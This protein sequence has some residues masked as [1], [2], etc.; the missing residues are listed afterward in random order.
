MRILA[1][2]KS[3]EEI[4]VTRIDDVADIQEDEIVVAEENFVVESEMQFDF[5]EEDTSKDAAPAKELSK[6]EEEVQ[7]FDHDFEFLHLKFKIY[8]MLTK[9]KYFQFW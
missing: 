8:L 7:G 3:R 4:P 1:E 2:E 9:V 6:F 5:L